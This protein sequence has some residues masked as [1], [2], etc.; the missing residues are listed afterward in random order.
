MCAF[1]TF[2]LWCA[3]Q[4]FQK[5]DT[6]Q[7]YSQTFKD[8]VTSITPHP[9]P[10]KLNLSFSLPDSLKVVQMGIWGV[11]WLLT[12]PVDAVWGAWLLVTD[13]SLWGDFLCPL[14]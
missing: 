5:L 14:D 9:P 7:L 6:C 12:D 3:F 11:G 4:F 8:L 13:S 1:R 2:I 10:P